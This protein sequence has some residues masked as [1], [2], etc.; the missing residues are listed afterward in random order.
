M[1]K[2]KHYLIIYFSFIIYP[3]F[4]QVDTDSLKEVWDNSTYPDSVRLQAINELAWEGYLFT[5]PDSAYF[6]AQLQFELAK[7]AGMQK[8]MAVARNT[9]GTSFYMM[10]NYARAVDYFYQSLKIK[11]EINDLKGIAAT[12]NNIGMVNDEQGDHKKAI[13][14][15]SQAV[16]HIMSIP[17]YEKKPDILQV[18]VASYHNLGALFLNV[19]DYEEA[20][21][22]FNKTLQLTEQ[23]ELKRERAY[24]YSN[25]GNMYFDK[26]EYATSM[27]Y[28]RKA[29][30]ILGSIKDESGKV[31]ALLNFSMIF[32]QQGNYHQAIEYGKQALSVAKQN[33]FN[34]ELMEASEI[35]YTSYKN[36]GNT[37]KALEMF[38]LYVKTRDTL[39]IEG[40]KQ[41]VIRQEYKYEYEKQ[42]AADSIAFAAREEIQNL[43][44]SEQQ[45]QLKAEEA[46]RL[47]LYS[48]VGLL[49]LLSFVGYRG[50]KR[51]IEAN[52]IIT[53]KKIE[54]EEQRDKIAEFNNTL[55]AQVK[56]RTMELEQSLRQIRNYQFNLSHNIRGPYVTLIGLLNLI[57]DE[58]FDSTENKEVLQNLRKTTQEMEKVLGHISHDL[59]KIDNKIKVD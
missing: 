44:I 10:G 59:Q 15:Y 45:A 6:Y 9:Q 47:M 58:R 5:K 33:N 23:L 37:T 25:L 29:Y 35:L 36:L 28:Y 53:Q 2:V 57:Q 46:Q 17:E 16:E 24:T 11:E 1:G 42:S 43:K 49:I 19:K 14:N 27:S 48:I 7:E 38:E 50:Y 22:Y 32:I 30:E 26:K 18:L 13:E 31:D 51:K 12:L 41:E 4:S 20:L 54:V 21:E 39:Q 52:R 8:E 56:K 34:R 40:N 55:E 3:L